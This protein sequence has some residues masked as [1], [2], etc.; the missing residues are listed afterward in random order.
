M[1]FGFLVAG[2]LAFIGVVR[3]LPFAY[4]AY[5]LVSLAPAL[6][7]PITPQPLDSL[8]RYELVVFPFFMWA[9]VWL[10]GRRREL[11]VLAVFVRAP[12]GVHG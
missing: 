7:Y 1:L 11:A 3:R 5:A 2:V 4:A 12:G 6:S 10:A 8:P 9:A